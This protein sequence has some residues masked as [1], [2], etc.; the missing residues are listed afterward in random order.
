MLG[1]KTTEDPKD[2]IHDLALMNSQGSYSIGEYENVLKESK[3]EIVENI[4]ELMAM[5]K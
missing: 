4:K 1:Y 3:N 5:V 2:A